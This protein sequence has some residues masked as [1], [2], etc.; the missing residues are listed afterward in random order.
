MKFRGEF[1]EVFPEGIVDLKIVGLVAGDIQKGFVARK[2]KII[3]RG[4]ESDRFAALSVQIAPV[5]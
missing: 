2:F 3:P 4:G 1:V 5:T